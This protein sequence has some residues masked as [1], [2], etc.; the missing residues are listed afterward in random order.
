MSKD[1]VTFRDSDFTK[2]INTRKEFESLHELLCNKI[3]EV[4]ECIGKVGGATIDY[5]YFRGAEEGEYGYPSMHGYQPEDMDC[6]DIYE[7]SWKKKTSDKIKSEWLEFWNYID[8]KYLTLDRDDLIEELKKDYNEFAEQI[9]K[10]K[11]ATKA[12]KEKQTAA[13]EKAL[14]K[15]TAAERRALGV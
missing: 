8:K 2:Y 6:F 4:Y 5:W 13:K 3:T 12:K 10:E 15:L 9:K 1:A 7:Y 14:K 11:E